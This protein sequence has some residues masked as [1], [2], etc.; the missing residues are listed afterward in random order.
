MTK[1][2]KNFIHDVSTRENAIKEFI[3]LYGESERGIDLINAI[4]DSF[5]LSNEEYKDFIDSVDED[6]LRNP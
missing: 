2:N 4:F 3:R 5:E 6:W 1:W